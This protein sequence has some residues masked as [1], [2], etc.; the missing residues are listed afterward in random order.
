M[1]DS[2]FPAALAFVWQQQFDSPA[3]GYHSTPGDPGGATFG[4][5]IQA[6]WDNA[7]QT[8]VV[9][10][11]LQYASIAQL[12]TVLRTKFWSP[13]CAAL[14]PGVDLLVFNGIMMSG[15]FPELLQQSLG[16]T[17]GSVDGW[18]GKITQGAAAD[19]DPVTLIKAV[20][21]IHD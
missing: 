6:T 21:G 16:L 15:H 13:Y 20:H 1:T 3:Q 17:D 14:P 18:I 2:N 9:S 10:G 8:G 11:E 19:S 12:T 5:V 7:V 4:G